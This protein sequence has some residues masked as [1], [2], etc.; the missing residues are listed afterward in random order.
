MTDHEKWYFTCDAGTQQGPVSKASLM[1]MIAT[2]EVK[3]TNMVWK[4][5]MADWLFV[6]QVLELAS[7]EP[8]ATSVAPD[9]A[10]T[11]PQNLNP[12]APPS[13]NTEVVSDAV[14]VFSTKDIT[15]YPG[16]GRLSYFFQF[17]GYFVGFV[18]IG[19]ATVFLN[20]LVIAV[21]MV[22]VL[23]VF[24]MRLHYRR[25]INIGMNGWWILA[26]FIPIVNSIIS[27]MLLACPTGYADT[28]KLD[29][30]GAIIGS[31]LIL[32]FIASFFSNSAGFV[33]DEFIREY[34]Q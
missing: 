19:F 21:L 2:N 8:A 3:P 16:I 15:D 31:I 10:Q 25:L 13:S 1:Q 18:A 23:F 30:P 28:K 20:S 7:T 12:Y 22:V 11:S 6:S 5:G 33:S 32:L 34:F 26:I 17:I 4:E 9:A 14:D 24:M 27:I 29:L